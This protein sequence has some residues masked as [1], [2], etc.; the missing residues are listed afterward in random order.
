[1][2]HDIG[3]RTQHKSS[4][5]QLCSA[6]LPE[7]FGVDVELFEEVTRARTS[8]LAWRRLPGL[9]MSSMH[10]YSSMYHG[11]FNTSCVWLAHTR[12]APIRANARSFSRLET[13]P[14]NHSKLRWA[15]A[16]VRTRPVNISN[17]T[18]KEE[19]HAGKIFEDTKILVRIPSISRV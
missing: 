10:V 5:F 11:G 4:Q 2:Q 1:L 9:T 12:H 18:E 13:Q 3:A 17:L 16:A 19:H 6:V 8:T 7:H 15:S 14:S